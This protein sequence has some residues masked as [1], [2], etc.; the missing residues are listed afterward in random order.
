MRPRSPNPKRNAVA[1]RFSDEEIAAVDK[2]ASGEGVLTSPWVRE[3]AV[4]KAR[5]EPCKLCR[6]CKHHGKDGG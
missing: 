4:A 5:G 3:A 6:A 2:A 1:V